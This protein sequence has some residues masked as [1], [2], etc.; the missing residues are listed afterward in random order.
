MTHPTRSIS[1]YLHTKLITTAKNAKSYIDNSLQ[2]IEHLK[3]IKT[4]K[5][6][7]IITADIKSLYTNI[8]NQEGIKTVTN[9]ATKDKNNSNK[10]KN[11]TT[12]STLLS[13]VLNNNIFAFNKR[14]RHGNHHGP[15]LR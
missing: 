5:N 12:L 9:E 8:P 3:P 15:H 13:L 6:T 1:N 11:P 4:T 10:I 7:I 2:L 14:H